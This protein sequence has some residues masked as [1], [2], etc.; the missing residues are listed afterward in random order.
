M[1]VVIALIVLVVLLIFNYKLVS[2]ATENI[3]NKKLRSLIM[4]L[5]NFALVILFY[6]ILSLVGGYSYDSFQD[7]LDLFFNEEI[8]ASSIIIIVG[9][10]I[11]IIY[12]AIGTYSIEKVNRLKRKICI[13]QQEIGALEKQI[14]G[15]KS[16]AHL[17]VLLDI[18]SEDLSELARDS[19]IAAITQIEV[20]LQKK[21]AELKEL[22]QSLPDKNVE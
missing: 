15:I 7:V 12:F 4:S 13:C 18:C 22:T 6:I 9:F 10:T 17:L 1:E 16:I 20:E 19:E 5:E 8:A 21:Y 11:A 3:A 14:Q 2:A